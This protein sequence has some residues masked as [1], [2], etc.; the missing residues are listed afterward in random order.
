[1]DKV[2]WPA[3]KT[4]SPLLKGPISWICQWMEGRVCW[5]MCKLCER[6]PKRRVKQL[7]CGPRGRGSRKFVEFLSDGFPGNLYSWPPH[8]CKFDSLKQLPPL[9]LQPGATQA[10]LWCSSPSTSTPRVQVTSYR[11]LLAPR[12]PQLTGVTASRNR[13]RANCFVMNCPLPPTHA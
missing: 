6:R 12:P 13:G 9:G 1:M 3:T 11:T 7:C 2:G 5:R 10:G 8:E 4:C